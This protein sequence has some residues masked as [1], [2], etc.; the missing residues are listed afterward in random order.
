MNEENNDILT[1]YL[2]NLLSN[3]ILKKEIIDIFTPIINKLLEILY[4]YI[5][6]ITFIVIV[7]FILLLTIL[8][9]IINPLRKKP[10]MYR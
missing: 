9:F 6:L 1:K 3:K 5:Y 7:N 8:F 4:P 10:L 2:T